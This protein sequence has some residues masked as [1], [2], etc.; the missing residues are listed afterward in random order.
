MISTLVTTNVCIQPILTSVCKRNKKYPQ[1]LIGTVVG[2]DQLW[3][4]A[5]YYG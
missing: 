1:S 2:D 5:V 4:T 3:W